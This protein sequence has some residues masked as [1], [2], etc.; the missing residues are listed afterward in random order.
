MLIQPY[1]ENAIWHGLRYKKEKGWLK[2]EIRSQADNPQAIEI[3][4]S[5][6]GIGRTKSEELKTTNQKKHRSSGLKNTE[7]R[8]GR[9][10]GTIINASHPR[11]NKHKTTPTTFEKPTP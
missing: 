2:V 8:I 10:C 5:D 3:I 9:V 1:I 11:R 6:N 7:E 4:I